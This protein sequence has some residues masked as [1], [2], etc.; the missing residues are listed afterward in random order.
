MLKIKS[1]K[2]KKDKT[3]FMKNLTQNLLPFDGNV[4]LQAFSLIELLITLIIV[5]LL[6]GAFSPIITKKLKASD[7][8][9]G[10]FGKG[11]SE[12]N[13][14]GTIKRPITEE[15]CKNWKA[16]FIPASM[17]DGIK[18]V[19]VTKFNVGDGG[20]PIAK[21]VKAL[22]A[23]QTCPDGASCC[24]QGI[25]NGYYTTN[26]NNSTY[27]TQTRTNCNFNA[28]KLSC[29]SYAPAGSKAG[30]WRLPKDTE[31][32]GWFDNM[33]SLNNGK[34]ENGLQLCRSTSPNLNNVDICYPQ[35]LNA[36]LPNNCW[37]MHLWLEPQISDGNVYSAYMWL[38]GSYTKQQ[39]IKGKTIDS[40]AFSARCVIDSVTETTEQQIE[41]KNNAPKSQADCDKFNALFIPANT[42]D[43][44]NNI[45]VT[46]WN[47][48]DAGLPLASGT[49]IVNVGQTC[50]SYGN[51]CWKGQTAE[52][53]LT[54]RNSGS[55]Y[56]TQNR[57]V[58]HLIPAQ[59]ACYNYAPNGTK[60]GDWR[61]PN[62]S[63]TQGWGKNI[64]LLNNN[65][66]EN[67]LQLCSA[68]ATDGVD[69]C[70]WLYNSCKNETTSFVKNNNCHP[71]L[72]K[73]A[74]IISA[75]NSYAS[76]GFVGFGA[77]GTDN[78]F[79][80]TAHSLEGDFA[81]S[82]RCV[83]DGLNSTQIVQKPAE[84]DPD[85]EQ[86][87]KTCN[88]KTVTLSDTNMKVTQYNMG[89]DPACPRSVIEG[90]SGVTFVPVGTN[91]SSELCCWYGVTAAGNT[92]TNVGGIYS[93]CN[94][95]VC[96][97][98]AAK[99]ICESIGDGWKLPDTSNSMANWYPNN[100]TAATGLM[101]CDHST[102]S[103]SA[104][105]CAPIASCPGTYSGG[106]SPN[107]LWARGD[108]GSNAVQCR[109]LYDGSWIVET[110]EKSVA[111]GVR[112][113]KE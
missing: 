113:T 45:C 55:T 75:P 71:Y 78:Y 58:C 72:L 32:S 41:L 86:S 92:C 48:G 12:G 100:S 23:G 54:G 50:T 26:K 33:A 84:K 24:W 73:T 106:C 29:S 101:L 8:V 1:N 49:Q 10:S 66:G 38:Y 111:F 18:N 52:M 67:G 63:E 61:L 82:V 44:T 98:Y 46:K 5:S 15:D 25:T 30:D 7:I 79:T 102:S 37:T 27:S 107:G 62:I 76:T 35:N 89:D 2:Q 85:P 60:A 14:Y 6:I 11:D 3:D 90:M 104:S 9:V 64:A 108:S 56:S 20:I 112:C 17:N 93:G 69:R 19:C 57:T 65:K 109:Y 31:I 95:T 91:C 53:Y 70:S 103:A 87:Q 77:I 28:S 13:A 105:K 94:R 97:W 74:T 4:K 43:G 36:C 22:K 40:G 99:K 68:Y 21:S 59:N 34:G 16:L 83:Y 110:C 39:L 81:A 88:P 47:M 42:N 51:C 80:V 96:K